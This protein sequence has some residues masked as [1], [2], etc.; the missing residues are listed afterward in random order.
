MINLRCSGNGVCV[1]PRSSGAKLPS[2]GVGV[3]PCRP[4]SPVS[5]VY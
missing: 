3:L 2:I 1:G 5:L 4:L